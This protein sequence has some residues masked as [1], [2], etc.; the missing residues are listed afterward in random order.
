[1]TD[2]R[3]H[4][5]RFIAVAVLLVGASFG[6][7]G[8]ALGSPSAPGDQLWATIYNGPGSLFD[9]ARAVTVSLD[10]TEVDV[11]GTSSNSSLDSD[12]TTAAYDA[13]TGSQDWMHDTTARDTS[14]TA[15]RP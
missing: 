11:A 1:M 7:S 2:S 5:L 13:G 3:V 12:A 14:A 9:E 6:F 8:R 10:G 4:G 15:S